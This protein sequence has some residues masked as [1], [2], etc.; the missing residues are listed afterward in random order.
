MLINSAPP[1][2]ALAI[3]MI[4]CSFF[5]RC[6]NPCPSR[7][8]VTFGAQ[9][10]SKKLNFPPSLFSSKLPIKLVCEPDR[11]PPPPLSPASCL[12][13]HGRSV[14]GSGGFR[15]ATTL[16][17][18]TKDRERGKRPARPVVGVKIAR[19]AAGEPCTRAGI[20]CAESR[21][22][23]VRGRQTHGHCGPAL[24]AIFGDGKRKRSDLASVPACL[25]SGSLYIWAI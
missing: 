11:A 9:E 16:D 22:S 7:C 23:P 2:A 10:K 5:S 3:P 19:F 21:C 8:L 17:V 24:C 6:R 18:K 4:Y 1:E 20:A 14:K 15:A 12:Q 13:W 25:S